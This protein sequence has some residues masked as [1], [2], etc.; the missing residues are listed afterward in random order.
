[1]L[2]TASLVL[3]LSLTGSSQGTALA[4]T[5]GPT[6]PPAEAYVRIVAPYSLVPT[7]S[8]DA[9]L[10]TKAESGVGQAGFTDAKTVRILAPDGR[11]IGYLVVIVGLDTSRDPDGTLKGLLES[12][13]EQSASPTVTMIDGRAIVTFT[14]AGAW[15]EVWFDHNFFAAVFAKDEA[16]VRLLGQAVRDAQ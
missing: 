9:T 16:S 3:L 2:P 13:G 6:V 10:V 1:V 12:L 11:L 4:P 7:T 8:E 14:S 15:S 5:P